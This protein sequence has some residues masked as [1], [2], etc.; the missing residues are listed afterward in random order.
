MVLAAAVVHVV[1]SRHK[2]ADLV[3]E[4]AVDI[5]IVLAVEAGRSLAVEG[6]AVGTAS[7]GAAED[8]GSC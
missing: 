2:E 8:T 4:E 7:E 3:Q 6:Q 5:A 1:V